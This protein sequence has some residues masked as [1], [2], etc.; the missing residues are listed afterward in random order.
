M[1]YNPQ[2]ITCMFRADWKSD[3][4]WVLLKFALCKRNEF[5]LFDLISD[6]H[7]IGS[8]QTEGLKSNVEDWVKPSTYLSRRDRWRPFTLWFHWCRLCGHHVILG[9]G[10]VLYERYTTPPSSRWILWKVLSLRPMQFFACSEVDAS[11]R[12][13]TLSPKSHPSDVA[14]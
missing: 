14:K 5:D 10:T 9:M 2:S 1:R 7:L 6:R 8:R 3:P 12:K 4:F 11:S 13:S